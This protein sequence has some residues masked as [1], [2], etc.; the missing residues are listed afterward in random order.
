MPPSACMSALDA[1]D[2]RRRLRRAGREAARPRSS[3]S[4][5][6]SFRFEKRFPSRSPPP[7]SPR[8][9]LLDVGEVERRRRLVG[10]EQRVGLLA[11]LPVDA[12][13]RSARGSICRSSSAMRL[14]ACFSTKARSATKPTRTSLTSLFGYWRT[15]AARSSRS[16]SPAGRRSGAGTS[17]MIP[18]YCSPA[19]RAAQ[20]LDRH[21]AGGVAGQEL[22]DVAAQVAVERGRPPGRRDRRHQRQRPEQHPMA[23]RPGD[24]AAREGAGRWAWESRVTWDGA[25]G[26]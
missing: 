21:D 16:R 25:R 17:T 11:V 14:P 13:P 6:P 7:S 3:I 23:E 18:R 24:E 12:V 15:R 1:V 22:L 2:E 8:V 19:I 9:L 5:R 10:V 20:L 4:V 26:R